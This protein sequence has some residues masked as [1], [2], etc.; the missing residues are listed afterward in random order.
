[1]KILIAGGSGMI[2]SV[3]APYLKA[4]GHEVSR[5]VRR[6]PGAAE[7]RWDPVADCIDAPA[8]EGFDGVVHLASMPW[9]ARWT[10]KAKQQI[11]E[12]RMQTNSLL[13]KSL[14]GCQYPPRALICASGMGIYPDSGDQLLT[15]DSRLGTDFLAHLQQ[16][17]EAAT[18]PASAAGIRV[19][20]LPIPAVLGGEGL[21]RNMGRIGSGRQ[22]TSWV[23]RDELASIVEFILLTE[24]LNGPVNPVSPN[25]VQNAEFVDILSRVLGRKPGMLVPAFLLRL[26]LGEMAEALILASRRILPTKLLAAGYVF[27]FA[28]LETALRHELAVGAA[29]DDPALVRTEIKS[30]RL[31]V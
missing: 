11:Y 4:Q 23:G 17:G 31:E 3:V 10:P 16:D 26:M 30:A 6:E 27:R 14:A 15:E 29:G 20:N 8:L 21:K 24:E 13:A 22:W 1:M 19:V 18:A 5:L 25:P 2:G 28:D 7:V 12:N 9:P